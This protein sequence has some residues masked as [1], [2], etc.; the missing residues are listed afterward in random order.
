LFSRPLTSIT[1]LAKRLVS[2]WNLLPFSDLPFGSEGSILSLYNIHL[3]KN[4]S[5][6]VSVF[7]EQLLMG[8]IHLSVKNGL[9]SQKIYFCFSTTSPKGQGI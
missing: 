9:L 5:D 6:G 2:K 8:Y 4:R 3:F 1:N 7:G